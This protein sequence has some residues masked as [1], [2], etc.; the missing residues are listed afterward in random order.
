MNNKFSIGVVVA[1][2]LQVS[3]F[4]WWTAQQAQTIEQL[5]SQVTELTSRMAVEEA[6]NMKRDIEQFR[7]DF[8]NGAR[9]V[10]KGFGDIEKRLDRYEAELDAV[11]QGNNIPAVQAINVQFEQFDEWLDE[12]D[13]LF[14]DLYKQIEQLEKEIQIRIAELDKKLSDRMKQLNK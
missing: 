2:V 6:V 12:Y 7:N 5:N 14:D 1:I 9:E 11:S 4:V 10:A 8:A 13:I 3:A